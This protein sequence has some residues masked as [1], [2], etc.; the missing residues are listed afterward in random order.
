MIFYY[1][2]NSKNPK[3]WQV[4]E[5]SSQ[6]GLLCYNSSDSYCNCATVLSEQVRW[7][8]NLRKES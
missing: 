8:E 6:L 2:T 3:K 4:D 5:L 1:I 7:E